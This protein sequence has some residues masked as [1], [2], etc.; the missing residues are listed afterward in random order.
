M[1]EN[2]KVIV[3]DIDGTLCAAGEKPSKETIE[4]IEELRKRGY[5]F[6]LA[7]GRPADDLVN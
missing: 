3:S 7:S 4:T 2:I 5:L 6:G 1:F